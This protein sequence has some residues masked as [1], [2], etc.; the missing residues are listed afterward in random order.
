M[1][2]YRLATYKVIRWKCPNTGMY[3]EAHFEPDEETIYEY[4]LY[5]KDGSYFDSF[6]TWEEARNYAITKVDRKCRFSKLG[7]KLEI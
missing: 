4:S 7:E 6:D 5:F 1:K 3:I 2:I